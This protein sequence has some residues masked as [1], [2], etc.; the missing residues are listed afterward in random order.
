MI[1]P[2]VHVYYTQERKKEEKTETLLTRI[3]IGEEITP[4]DFMWKMKLKH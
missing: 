2:E 3:W 1:I 4:T